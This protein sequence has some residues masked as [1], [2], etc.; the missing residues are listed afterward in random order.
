MRRRC[1]HVLGISPQAHA[2]DCL[3]RSHRGQDTA[4]GQRLALTEG[5]LDLFPDPPQLRKRVLAAFHDEPVRMLEPEAQ[6]G[7]VPGGIA[8]ERGDDAHGRLVVEPRSRPLPGV[9]LAVPD[10][11]LE[12]ACQDR[13]EL[14]QVTQ[15][16]PVVH[17]PPPISSP[18]PVSMPTR[19]AEHQ[20]S[21]YL[22][23]ADE[24]SA[25]NRGNA[26]GLLT[27]PRGLGRWAGSRPSLRN[28]IALQ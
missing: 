14:R 7:V 21:L 5:A 28:A 9:L 22:T 26:P 10:Y 17:G 18:Q 25:L 12:V 23:Y 2:D 19:P 27:Q 11:G 20:D 16:L 15:I 4:A 8:G 3:S 1:G 6:R 24:C 13:L